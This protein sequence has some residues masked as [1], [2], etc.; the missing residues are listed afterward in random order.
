MHSADY[1][2]ARCPSVRLSVTRRNCVETDKHTFNLCPW[3]LV[4]LNFYFY[5]YFCTN[6]TL[7]IIISSN[8]FTSFANNKAKFFKSFNNIFGNVGCNVSDE[9]LLALVKTK[10]LP[11]L[12]YGV[13]AC[14]TNSS[15]NHFCLLWIKYS[16]K[17]L[18]PCPKTPTV[19]FT[20][21]LVLIIWTSFFRKRQDKFINKFCAS[22]NLLCRGI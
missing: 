2:V 12:F 15:D 1:V 22:D 7:I 21:V 5:V 17:F 13:E 10:C 8:F 16:L 6:F 19:I 14:P 11:I 18:V 4:I 3:F 9:V 20:S